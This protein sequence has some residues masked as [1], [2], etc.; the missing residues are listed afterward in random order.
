MKVRF[1][2]LLIL[3]FS[4]VTAQNYETKKFFVY[5]FAR[6]V[7]WPD[8]YKSGD[9]EIFVLGDTPFIEELKGMAE[10]KKIGERA[11]KVTRISSLSE[12]KKCHILILPVGQSGQL[13]EALKKVGGASTLIVTEQEGLAA[14]GSDIN[15]VQKDG[16]MA[17]ELNQAALAKHKLKAANELSRLAIAI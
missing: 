3:G 4:W 14:K 7:V 11:I 9:F 12:Y 10:K 6:Y 16:K 1:T 17:F 8:E 13:V 2:L 15:F 5:S